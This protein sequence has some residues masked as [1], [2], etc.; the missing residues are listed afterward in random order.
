MGA[1]P[2][3]TTPTAKVAS[4]TM[5]AKAVVKIAPQVVVKPG[6]QVVVKTAPQ[7]TTNLKR[8]LTPDSHSSMDNPAQKRPCNNVAPTVSASKP[9]I[10]KRPLGQGMPPGKAPLGKAP[11]GKAPI[12][13]APIVK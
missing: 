6:P 10:A 11:L 1:S 8:P 13:K 5:P 9:P 7:T 2:A 12:S 3:K 4:S